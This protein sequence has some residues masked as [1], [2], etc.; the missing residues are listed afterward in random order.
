MANEEQNRDCGCV[1]VSDLLNHWQITALENC[2][3][4]GEARLGIGQRWAIKTIITQ[5]RKEAASKEVA[6][7]E[8]K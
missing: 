7:K 4:K 2:L 8:A 1:T 3:R 6:S 5:W